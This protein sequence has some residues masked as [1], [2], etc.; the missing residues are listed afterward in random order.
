MNKI[1]NTDGTRHVTSASMPRS[2]DSLVGQVLAGRYRVVESIGRGGMDT[3]YHGIQL[4]VDRDV[5][6]KVIKSEAVKRF[7]VEAHVVSR[8]AHAHTLR[9]YDFWQAEDG[10]LFLI[11]EFLQGTPLDKLLK[12]GRLTP[13]R[14]LHLLRQICGDLSEA[15]G[16]GIVHRDLKPSN[17]FVQKLGHEEF[18]KLIDFG[19]AKMTGGAIKTATG[20]I[21]GSPAYVSPEQ[22]RGD[23]MRPASDLYSLGIVAYECLTGDVPF[24]GST[25]YSV[26]LKHMNEQ[27]VSLRSI[28]PPIFGEEIDELVMTLLAKLPDDRPKSATIVQEDITWLLDN[29]TDQVIA[30]P[31]AAAP[32]DHR[33]V[34]CSDD[35]RSN[36]LWALLTL[37][38]VVAMGG[39]R[40]RADDDPQ[41]AALQDPDMGVDA[42][43]LDALAQIEPDTN[44]DVEPV[45]VLKS[46]PSKPC[47]VDT[48]VELSPRR[49][50]DGATERIKFSGMALDCRNRPLRGVTLR[51]SVEPQ[52][53][54]ENRF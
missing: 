44:P 54:P 1:S 13:V 23:K 35:P 27:P 39:W 32:N 5:A 16:K 28:Q 20:K 51:W 34:P 11:T 33:A 48:V 3:V 12:E 10:R 14:T 24:L 15:H 36:N 7:E 52:P 42:A 18:V 25:T 21:L 2:A 50:A 47:G 31:K 26:L 9:L 41:K 29:Q 46:A 38:P 43:E 40:M 17:I 30:R 4:N 19:I 49:S 22:A 6:I 37:L 53:L 45:A 8:L